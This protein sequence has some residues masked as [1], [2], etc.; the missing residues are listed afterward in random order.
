AGDPRAS[1][2]YVPARNIG[3]PARI[4]G[5]STAEGRSTHTVRKGQTLASIASQYGCSVSDIKRWNHLSANSVRRGTRLKIR[6]DMADSTGRLP[7]TADSAQIATIHARSRHRKGSCSGGA[8]VTVRRG[9][10]LAR[11]ARRH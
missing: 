9:D 1:T 3:P 10:T 2:D 7:A 6:S 11:I 8:T 5:Q 4:N